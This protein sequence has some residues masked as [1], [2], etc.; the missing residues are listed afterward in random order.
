MLELHSCLIGGTSAELPIAFSEKF[1]RSSGESLL[2]LFAQ[3]SD[4]IAIANGSMAR[5]KWFAN[6][7]RNRS[8]VPAQLGVAI[9]LIA[10]TTTMSALQ[11][12]MPT[13][14]FP[15]REGEILHDRVLPNFTMKKKNKLE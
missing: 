3:L 2:P 4:V 13:T 12:V 14:I 6:I 15:G 10:D 11:E 7:L 9:C 5:Q 8:V 1:Q